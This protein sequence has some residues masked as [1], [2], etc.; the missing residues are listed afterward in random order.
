MSNIIHELPSD[1]PNVNVVEEPAWADARMGEELEMMDGSTI[2]VN[3]VGVDDDRV[4]VYMEA[5][6]INDDFYATL[7]CLDQEGGEVYLDEFTEE[8]DGVLHFSTDGQADLTP[9]YLALEEWRGEEY[10]QTWYIGLE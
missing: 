8:D 1:D 4:S 3:A 10:L 9:E 5:D 2:V 7:I 6:I